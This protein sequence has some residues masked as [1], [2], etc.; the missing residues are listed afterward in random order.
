MLS[1]WIK[2]SLLTVVVVGLVFTLPA[3]AQKIG[4]S[5]K[6][7]SHLPTVK[8][9]LN[10]PDRYI[11]QELTLD[12][13]VD[14]VFSPSTFAIENDNNLF[15]IG[16]GR[17][18]VVS[19]WPDARIGRGELKEGKYVEATGTL[20]WFD[21][22]E[23]EREFGTIDFGTTPMNKFHSKDP[24]LIMGAREYAA[25]HRPVEIQQAVVV[26]PPAPEPEPVIEAAPPPP[27]PPVEPAPAPEPIVEPP[28]APTPQPEL[29]RTAT[30]LPLLA[31][32]GLF[33]LA[34]SFGMRSFRG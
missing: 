18:L 26:P 7:Y 20:R 15:F 8:Q 2:Y 1:N 34:V 31:L 19:V 28:P 5:P 24:V 9:V 11:G 32:G 12:G 6:Q 22:A 3:V 25:A 4:A 14:H 16:E 29:P 33:S 17:V 23:L 10:H 30:P 27:P 21:R 13:E